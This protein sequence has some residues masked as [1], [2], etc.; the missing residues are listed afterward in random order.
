M[1]YTQVEVCIDQTQPVLYVN[2]EKIPHESVFV[3]VLNNPLPPPP[4]LT[5]D[6]YWWISKCP[7][8][9]VVFCCCFFDRTI[10]LDQGR[11]PILGNKNLYSILI[12]S[13]N[14]PFFFNSHSLS[15]S[16]KKLA[17]VIHVTFTVNWYHIYCTLTYPTLYTKH[18][19]YCTQNMTS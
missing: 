2:Q 5:H 16:Q 17:I 18:H 19:I 12:F 13:Q 9:F 6:I 11:T 15:L 1:W 8:C 7:G 4:L 14:A 3:T 10:S